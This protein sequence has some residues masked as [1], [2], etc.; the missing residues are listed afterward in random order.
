MSSV[1]ARGEKGGVI[2]ITG[3]VC[4]NEITT[5]RSD[6]PVVGLACGNLVVRGH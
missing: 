1:N 2:A 4:L 6:R 5:K 3:M